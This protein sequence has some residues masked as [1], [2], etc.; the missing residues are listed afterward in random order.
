[1]HS[2]RFFSASRCKP[3]N[4]LILLAACMAL[5]MMLP[6]QA[7]T[8]SVL[9]SFKGPPDGQSP[10]GGIIR[11]RTGNIYGVTYGGGAWYEGTAFELIRAQLLWQR[12]RA[13]R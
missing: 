13:V 4:L 3:F 5:S 10:T 9:Y 2:D 7:E 6:A 12:E 11:D 1:M 8:F